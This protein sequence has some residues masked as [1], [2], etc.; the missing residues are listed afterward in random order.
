MSSSLFK[1][2]AASWLLC[3]QLSQVWLTNP[4]LLHHP[5]SRSENRTEQP[6]QQIP[7]SYNFSLERNGLPKKQQSSSIAQHLGQEASSSCLS[8]RNPLSCKS[9]LSKVVYMHVQVLIIAVLM[10]VVL[11]RHFS[12]IQWEAL[13]LLC[14]GITINQFDHCM[15]THSPKSSFSLC[16]SR[17]PSPCIFV[18]A[19]RSTRQAELLLVESKQIRQLL[20]EDTFSLIS[21]L[22]DHHIF[23]WCIS[24]LNADLI[25]GLRDIF[26]LLPIWLKNGDCI[27]ALIW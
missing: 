24:P 7:G 18:C 6:Q 3:K 25:S 13:V 9:R 5:I 20:R 12:I 10:K 21:I 15:W 2:K 19:S 4:F 22:L 27:Q 23:Q 26:Y 11:Q 1:F 14:I 8:H 17:L 16:L